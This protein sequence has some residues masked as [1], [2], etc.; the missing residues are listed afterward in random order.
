MFALGIGASRSKDPEV[1]LGSLA[2]LRAINRPLKTKVVSIRIVKIELPHSVVAV[3]GWFKFD[4]V[5]FQVLI[6]S[7][8]IGATEVEARIP[9]DGDVARLGRVGTFIII[10]GCI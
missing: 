8:R 2:Y 4:S 7:I 6:R 1:P 10:V 9:M 5:A 3:H